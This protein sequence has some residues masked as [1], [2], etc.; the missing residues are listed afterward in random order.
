MKTIVV[1]LGGNALTKKGE[2]GSY[3]ELVRNINN[4]TK[5]LVPLFRYSV[6]LV[7]GSGPQIGNLL[8]QNEKGREIIPAM[9]LYVL[10]AELEGEL[11]FLIE[12]SIDNLKKKEALTLIT[13]VLVDKKDKAFRNPT[14]FV[15]PYYKKKQKGGVFE[16]DPRGGF[17][18][19]V[20]SPKP[21]KIIEDNAIKEMMKE[22]VV[23]CAGGGGIPVYYNKGKLNGVEAVIDKDLA[24]ACL[25]N[26]INADEMII[27]TDVSNAYLN[28]KKKNQVKINKIKLKNITKYFKQG[29]FGE[30]SMGPKVEAAIE[31]LSK[32]GKRVII[33]N[34]ENLEKALRGKTGTVITR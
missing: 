3:K 16:K 10:D 31:F 34:P 29:H 2:R 17:R 30:G 13:R 1:S 23:I 25:A 14:K 5:R 15:G 33:T 18:R 6:A 26:S 20:A 24:S 28:F 22:H 11:G 19:V 9:P 12:E 8:L 32:K 4:I 21:L 27:L 7:S